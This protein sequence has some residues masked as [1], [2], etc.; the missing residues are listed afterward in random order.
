[1]VAG[2]L[3]VV[4]DSH[5]LTNLSIDKSF[6]F[7]YDSIEMNK[8]KCIL[9]LFRYYVMDVRPCVHVNAITFLEANSN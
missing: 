1:M 4:T 9:Q 7:E 6:R 2:P 8:W 3:Q 5:E